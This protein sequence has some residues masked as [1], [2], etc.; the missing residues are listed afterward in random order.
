M[1]DAA[2]S[3]AGGNVLVDSSGCFTNICCDT[4]RLLESCSIQE[5]ERCA[6]DEICSGGTFTDAADSERCCVRG[7]CVVQTEEDI[8]E[9]EARGGEC[10]T[11]CS[12]NEETTS[13]DCPSFDLCCVEETKE[14]NYILI[15]VLGILIL[16]LAIGIIFRDK[17]RKFW[18]KIKSKFKR[19]KSGPSPRSPPG[20]PPGPSSAIGQRP[21]Q[22]RVFPPTQRPARR[23]AHRS[24]GELDNVLKKLKEMGK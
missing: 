6:S 13:D 20:F 16:L 24:K 7:E 14:T 8:S 19:G 23:P 22:R 5:G 1:S 12:N 3:E 10:K 2:C 21:T 17:L 4:Q 18:F 15:L 9:C 11:T